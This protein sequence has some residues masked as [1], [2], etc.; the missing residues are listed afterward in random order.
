MANKDDKIIDFICNICSQNNSCKFTDL[1]RETASCSHCHST[2][3]MRSVIHCLSLGLFGVSVALPFFPVLKKVKGIGMSDW[4]VYA[5][6]LANRLDYTNTYYHTEPLLDIMNISKDIEKTLDF[7]ISTDVF[8][9][10]LSPVST[11][12][13][14]T[15]SLL[16]PGGLFVLT[17]PY[18][19]KGEQTTEHFKDL[20]KFE[21]VQNNSEYMLRNITSD[22]RVVEYNNLIFHGGPGQ[23]L[24]M[25]VFCEKALISE[26]ENA[27]FRDIKIHGEPFLRFGIQQPE[28][29]S[30]PITA[31]A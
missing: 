14:N 8:E 11:A 3:R 17:V 21:I 26:L 20:N 13:E 23:T 29:W 5:N 4:D 12:F 6:L 28:T 2:V 18:S 9:H 7:V 22:N 1:G 16:K 31:R 15:R 27:G 24:E 25:R 30:L 19:L 10:V